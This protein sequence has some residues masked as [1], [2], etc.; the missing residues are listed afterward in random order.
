MATTIT[1]ARDEVIER[2]KLAAGTGAQPSNTI[3]EGFLVGG[4]KMV[5][6]KCQPIFRGAFSVNAT[7]GVTTIST[8]LE[9][10]L[11]VASPREVLIPGAEWVETEDGI[12]FRAAN[13]FFPAESDSA[14]VWYQTAPSI[15]TSVE[16]SC[17]FGP[18][19]LEEPALMWA[20]IQCL[21]RMSRVHD[22]AGHNSEAAAWVTIQQ[23]LDREVERLIGVRERWIGFMEQRLGYRLQARAI[24]RESVLDFWN[25]ETGVRNELT[26][27]YPG[28]MG[29]RDNRY[30]G[31]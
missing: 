25:Q 22:S 28:S 24:R 16:S 14:L 3:I 29:Q 4:F 8:D 1:D 19:W 17:I 10:V 13:D 6:G 2:L 26:D 31:S 15:T 11:F 7:S 5:W 9:A 23:E 21:K 18:D 27:V 30:Y 20:E 12:N